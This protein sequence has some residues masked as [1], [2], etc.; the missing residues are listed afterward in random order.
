MEDNKKLY[1][2]TTFTCGNST[3][4]KRCHTD[5]SRAV[6]DFSREMKFKLK[7]NFNR[8]NCSILF[9]IKETQRIFTKSKLNQKIFMNSNSILD[10]SVGELRIGPNDEREHWK[11]ALAHPNKRIFRWHQIRNPVSKYE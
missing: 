7:K 6:L 5:T 11:E 2:K 3:T 4:V 9:Q 8:Q 1:L 10:T